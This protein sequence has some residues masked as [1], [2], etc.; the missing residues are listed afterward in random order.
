VKPI[1]FPLSDRLFRSISARL[2]R[3]D[4][5]NDSRGSACELRMIDERVL[6]RGARARG[7]SCSSRIVRACSLT[8]TTP[9]ERSITRMPQRI[10]SMR[11]R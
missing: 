1:V 5:E 8:I 2:G 3:S 11:R 10:P 7:S 4:I 9:P 6:D